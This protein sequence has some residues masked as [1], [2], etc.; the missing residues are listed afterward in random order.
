MT[1]MA[2]SGAVNANSLAADARGLDAL[3]RSANKA[4]QEAVRQAATQF[5]ALFMNMLMKSMRESLPKEDPFAS[6]A[7]RSFTGMLDQQMSQG[8]AGKG[9]GLADMMVKQLTRQQGGDV[10]KLDGAKALSKSAAPAIKAEQQQL[11]KKLDAANADAA[12]A[13]K[14]G[15][16]DGAA[17]TA[18]QSFV[19]KMMPHAAEAARESG[20]PAHFMLGQAALESGWGKREIKS[21][22]GT[23]SHNLFGIKAGPG[24]KG[25]VVEATTTEYVNGVARK[26][27]EKFRAYASYAESFSDYSKLVASSPRY[28]SAMKVADNAGGGSYQTASAVSAFAQRIQSGGYATDPRYAEKL[29]K[30]INQT[31]QMQRVA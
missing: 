27:T 10:S 8:L 24:W 1:T 14:A 4:P 19:R 26:Q 22:D 28:A 17:Q 11:L 13:V 15:D 23:P 18:P 2:S 7:T 3:K 16:G 30:T 21:A 6:E 5:E 12:S 31:L 9:L 20:I 29:T 25:A